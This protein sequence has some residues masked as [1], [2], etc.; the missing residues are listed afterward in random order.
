V[1][2]SISARSL[3]AEVVVVYDRVL[4]IRISSE[5]L[6]LAS[7]WWGVAK[8]RLDSIGNPPWR[9]TIFVVGHDVGVPKEDEPIRS[10]DSVDCVE[11]DVSRLLSRERSRIDLLS[12]CD[13]G[14]EEKEKGQTSEKHHALQAWV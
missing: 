9:S 5:G 11:V 6:K 3:K 7:P 2:T 12:E 1:P 4:D 14:K 13:G 8:R 10:G